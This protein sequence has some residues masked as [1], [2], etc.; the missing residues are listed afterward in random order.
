MEHKGSEL[1]IH[2]SHNTRM[3]KVLMYADHHIGFVDLYRIN[4]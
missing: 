2:Y 1:Y 3:T 4:S